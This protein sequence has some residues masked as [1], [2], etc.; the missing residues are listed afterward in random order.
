MWV[1]LKEEKMSE[2]KK[3]FKTDWGRI[4]VDFYV[5]NP[6]PL[7]ALMGLDKAHVL[8]FYDGEEKRA[9][10]EMSWCNL[11]M[12]IAAFL[13]MNGRDDILSYAYID[14]GTLEQGAYLSLSK[15]SAN[16][17]NIS[18][19]RDKAKRNVSVFQRRVLLSELVSIQK[20]IMLIMEKLLHKENACE[21]ALLPEP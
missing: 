19:I 7:D 18:F 21:Q 3:S 9:T 12:Q 5:S 16:S 2:H 1:V 6:N 14:L 17:I 13:M 11:P 15:E 8:E 10:I 4:D 20:Y